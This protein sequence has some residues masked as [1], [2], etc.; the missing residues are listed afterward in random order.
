M[1][2]S[3]DFLRLVGR[4]NEMNF[5]TAAFEDARRGK[6]V[7]VLA[8]GESGVGK[9]RLVTEFTSAVAG[10]DA[11]VLSG[12]AIDLA[13]APPFW[14][15]TDAMRKLLR[16]PARDALADYWL[17]TWKQALPGSDPEQAWHL[18]RPL[19]ALRT[20]AVYQHFLDNI[21]PS[22]RIYHEEDVRPALEIAARLA[23]HDSRR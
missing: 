9:T 14:P 12:A 8:G 7:A 6:T 4:A 17:R 2:E 1:G 15:V 18:L 20:A 16:G 21:E 3:G 22:E 13:D 19:A 23:A 10:D 11:I 5:L